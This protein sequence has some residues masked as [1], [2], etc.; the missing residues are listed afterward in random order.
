MDVSTSKTQLAPLPKEGDAKDMLLRDRE[1]SNL[2]T[3]P[4]DSPKEEPR[5]PR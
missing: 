1:A 2:E 4:L 3:L 5:P